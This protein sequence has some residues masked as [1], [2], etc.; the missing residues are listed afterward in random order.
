MS[1]ARTQGRS[2]TTRTIAATVAAMLFL[3]GLPFT[4]AGGAPAAA[5]FGAG[6]PARYNENINGDFLLIGNTVLR[7][8]SS[9]SHVPVLGHEQRRPE[10]D[11]QRPGRHRRAV[12]RL[13]RLVHHPERGRRRRRLPVLGR[14]LRLEEQLEQV[15]LQPLEGLGLARH[16]RQVQGEHGQARRRHRRV[17]DD[18]LRHPLHVPL[19]W[20]RPDAEHLERRGQQRTRLR[21]GV[22][23]LLALRHR[24]GSE[25]CHGEGRRHPGRTGQQLP[26]GLGARARVPLP[27][28]QLPR[29]RQR[30]LEAQRLPQRRDLRRPAQPAGGLLGHDHDAVGLH[31]HRHVVAELGAAPRRDRLG[32]RPV[33]HR[34]PPAGEGHERNRLRH[35]RRP[36]RRLGDEQLLRQRQAAERG[37][38]LRHR[39]RPRLRSGHPARLRRTGAAT[40]TASTPRPSRSRC[41]VAPTPSTSGS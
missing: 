39:R 41:R 36:G 1:R 10:H 33:H 8:G 5:D 27:R 19:G 23:R 35:R 26:R 32:G 11:Q 28:Q 31:H 34:R 3:T 37:P 7:C 6:Q 22:G 13:L 20:P 38:Q 4:W 24:G 17:L 29:R 40:A 2:R 18:H 30:R 15:L 14:Q 21:S 9:S 25:R 16:R 12:Q